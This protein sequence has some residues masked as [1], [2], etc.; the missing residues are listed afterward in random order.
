[1]NTSLVLRSLLRTVLATVVM[2]CGPSALADGPA[3]DV[4]DVKKDKPDAKAEG[5]APLPH[6]FA[7][8]EKITTGSVTVGKQRVD[9]RA[10][11]GTLVV[12]PKGWDDVAARLDVEDKDK[13]RDKKDEAGGPGK[14]GKL[15]GAEAS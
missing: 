14:T 6:H 1:M 13:E 7:P 3:K 4:R 5:D 10:I 11:A 2:G 9:Y 15:T 8:E 12:H